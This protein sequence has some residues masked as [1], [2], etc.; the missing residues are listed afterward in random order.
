MF[1]LIIFKIGIWKFE[2]KVCIVILMKFIWLFK[3]IFIVIKF[4]VNGGKFNDIVIGSIKVKI[5]FM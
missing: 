1:F 4:N 2:D 3:L 5:E